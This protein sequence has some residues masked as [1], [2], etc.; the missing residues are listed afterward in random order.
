MSEDSVIVENKRF[1][2]CGCKQV[3]PLDRQKRIRRYKFGHARRGKHHTRET[4]EK[5]R[6][7]HLGRFTGVDAAGYIRGRRITNGYWDVLT[8]G[9]PFAHRNYV[10]EQRLVMEKMLG[11]Y[12][13]PYE[14]VHHKNHN[15]L[16]NREEN[17]IL[18]TK[19]THTTFHRIIYKSDHKCIKCKTDKTYLRKSRNNKPHWIFGM[20]LTCYAKEYYK[21][22][23]V[24]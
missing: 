8:H 11:R 13:E 15:K 5:L 9:H 1:C 21:K 19:S 14:V 12:L 3:V 7:T 17:L 6:Q 20:C 18:M 4:I 23:R 10:L 16:D 24:S 22:K 2:E